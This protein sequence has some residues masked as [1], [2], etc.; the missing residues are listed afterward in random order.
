MSLTGDRRVGF[1]V[2]VDRLK[3]RNASEHLRGLPEGAQE[4]AAHVIAVAEPGLARHLV[5]RMTAPLHEAARP[6]DP[7]VLDG[8]G[9]RLP[10]L[11]MEG[12][13]ELARAEM[14]RLGEIGDGERLVQVVP[15]RRRAPPGSGPISATARAGW[16][17]ATARR[18]D[19]DR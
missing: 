11:G 5:D 8:L 7:Q 18:R 13:A 17:T 12:A 10:R 9:G 19:G 2:D 14:R 1:V 3:P 15:V 16:K 6:F 4:G